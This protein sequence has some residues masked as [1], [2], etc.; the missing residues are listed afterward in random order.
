MACPSLPVRLIQ[1]QPVQAPAGVSFEVVH[2][3]LRRKPRIALQ[4]AR[5]CFAHGPPTD[6]SHAAHRPPESLPRRHRDGLDPR[7]GSAWRFGSLFWRRIDMLSLTGWILC[8]IW[9]SSGALAA[10]PSIAQ[11]W[12]KPEMPLLGRILEWTI[13]GSGFSP[14]SSTVSVFGPGCENG[15]ILKVDQS[16]STTTV[17][18]GQFPVTTVGEFT[19]KVKNAET[20]APE[21]RYFYSSFSP[22]IIQVWTNPS[23]PNIGRPFKVGLVGSGFD[24]KSAL[25]EIGCTAQSFCRVAVETRTFN[26]I[27]GEA[28]AL[29]AGQITTV[30][31]GDVQ[32][33]AVNAGS[34]SNLVRL[35]IVP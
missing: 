10:P 6:S 33:A 18:T 25:M 12:T 30:L 17:L 21:P 34:I 9:V 7:C 1:P 8:V 3:P 27:S 31:V 22:K 26:A 5:E 16:K 23:P 20:E 4:C 19:V 24:S 35:K 28:P 32:I 15:C 2:D 11:V 14:A 29:A 13:I